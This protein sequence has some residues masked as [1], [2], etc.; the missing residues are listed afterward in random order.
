[1]VVSLVTLCTGV[2]CVIAGSSFSPSF[3]GL[4]LSYCLQLGQAFQFATR[5]Y[6]EAESSFTAV[7]RLSAPVPQE[8]EL[9]KAPGVKEAV[10][11]VDSDGAAVEGATASSSDPVVPVVE[12]VPG[13]Q[14]PTLGA[15]DFVDVFVRYRPCLPL[16]LNGVTLRILPG[17]RVGT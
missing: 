9:W 14:W 2:L 1:M 17:E 4:A 6:S 10:A 5:Q 12:V 8:P 13:P 7:E 11:A 3:A 16:V 15:V